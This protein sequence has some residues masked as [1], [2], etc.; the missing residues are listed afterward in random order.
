[1]TSLRSACMRSDRAGISPDPNVITSGRTNSRYLHR[2]RLSCV[3]DGVLKW[4]QQLESGDPYGYALSTFRNH[5]VVDG[6]FLLA[7]IIAIASLY[8]AICLEVGILL[9]PIGYL[10]GLEALIV[11]LRHVLC[12]WTDDIEESF[13]RSSG[14]LCQWI[15]V[16]VYF[17]YTLHILG[18]M[19][20]SKD[21]STETAKPPAYPV[22]TTQ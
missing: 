18:K 3:F 12:W 20:R 14:D 11:T 9:Y 22:V 10:L 7:W 16:L 1:M 13:L 6:F 19:F 17:Y 5:V 21:R 15:V 4:I 2:P 8:Q